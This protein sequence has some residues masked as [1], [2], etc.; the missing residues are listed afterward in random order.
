MVVLNSKESKRALKRFFKKTLGKSALRL[1]DVGD[2]PVPIVRSHPLSCYYEAVLSYTLGC[3]NACIGAASMA[4]ELH[5]RDLMSSTIMD[6][7]TIGRMNLI[8]PVRYKQERKRLRS[9]SQIPY[10]ELIKKVERDH[11][12]YGALASTL[13]DHKA[14]N[15]IRT[16][17]IHHN[18]QKLRK[19]YRVDSTP[20]LEDVPQQ[21]RGMT[22]GIITG[23]RS[24]RPKDQAL[25][26]VQTAGKIL[27]T[28]KEDIPPKIGVRRFNDELEFFIRDGLV[29][30]RAPDE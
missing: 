8:S 3:F 23:L 2:I 28:K 7:V 12:M 5:L 11:Q 13:K 21:Y 26:A 19:A 18:P 10:G 17:H 20:H 9:L 14:M 1:E 27:G 15:T 25:A 30:E 29:P 22:V 4:T 6:S 24:S 16:A